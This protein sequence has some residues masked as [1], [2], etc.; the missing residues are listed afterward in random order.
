MCHLVEG[1][2]TLKVVVVGYS[3]SSS[4]SSSSGSTDAVVFAKHRNL[5][6]QA[7]RFDSATQKSV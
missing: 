4:S 3:S 1:L 2:Y 6:K 5:E 7:N